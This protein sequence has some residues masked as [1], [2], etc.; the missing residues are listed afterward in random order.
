[1]SNTEFQRD[2]IVRLVNFLD[3]TKLRELQEEA[4]YMKQFVSDLN[5]LGSSFHHVKPFNFVKHEAPYPDKKWKL[6]EYYHSDYLKSRVE[7]VTGLK[8]QHMPVIGDPRFEINCKLNYYDYYKA[9]ATEKRSKLG[10]HYDRTDQVKGK[11]VVAVLT[12]YNDLDD[13]MKAKT[14]QDMDRELP[15][16]SY[17]PRGSSTPSDIY[18]CANSL[19]IHMADDILHQANPIRVPESMEGNGPWHRTVFVVKFST[20]NTPIRNPLLSIARKSVIVGKTLA[21][22]TRTNSTTFFVVLLSISMV[23]SAAGI[24]MVL[25]SSMNKRR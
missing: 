1:M 20:D 17:F 5:V 18:S 4:S 13:L 23:L 24:A 14:L 16:L 15:T 8:L 21:I 2:G 6:V 10:W 7:E 19:E 11:I 9:N 25:S 22:G 3:A 12:L